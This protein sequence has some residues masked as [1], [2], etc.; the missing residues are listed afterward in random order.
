MR[1]L[2]RALVRLFYHRVEVVGMERV[3]RSG[4]LV[5][6]ANHRNALV[7]PLLLFATLPRTLQP[8]AKAPLFH[9]PLLAPFLRLAGA[10]PVHRRQDAG[11]DPARNAAMFRAVAAALRKGGAILIFPEGVS[12]PEPVLMPL[13]TGVARIVLGMEGD[14]G[15]PGATLLPVGLTYHEPGT[16]RSG[17][18]LVLV[19]AP[20]P[21]DDCR[22]LAGRE[23]ER[24]VRDLTARIAEALRALIVEG[25]DRET[26]RLVEG[27]EA[28]RRA[29]ATPAD[30]AVDAGGAAAIPGGASR[31]ERVA[32]VQLAT[33]AYRWLAPRAPARVARLRGEVEGYL[34]DLE[35]LGLSPQVVG[36]AYPPGVARRY[37]AREGLAL[38][39]GLPLAVWGLASHA[40]PYGLTALVARCLATSADVTATIKLV[41]GAV[42]YPAC[43]ALEAWA[44]W[45]WLGAWGLSAFLVALIPTGLF[46]LGW[47]ARLARVRRD[48][49]AFL[50]LLRDR[51]LFARLAARRRALVDET[52][53]L[54]RLLPAE[55]LT[56]GDRLRD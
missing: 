10:L 37:A 56:D 22:E 14:P 7:D 35:R 30:D 9:H 46:A 41:A 33:R 40:L 28:I 44:V 25:E 36:R 50:R 13:R 29:E 17:W 4:P 39:G 19:G 5:I 43:W 20:V 12:Q 54:A 11:S 15:T 24:A 31:A 45:R 26:L 42:L 34:A 52:D 18:A 49:W 32:W 51:D 27:L 48:A 6:V 55:V 38:V 21:I 47:Q 8:V 1:A 23:P 3:P 2:A 53:A 16:F